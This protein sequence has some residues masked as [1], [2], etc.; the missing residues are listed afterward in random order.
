[1]QDIETMVDKLCGKARNLDGDT[2]AMQVKD[3]RITKDEARERIMR[4]YV[5]FLQDCWRKA[6]FNE[7]MGLNEL[8]VRVP[9]LVLD[10]E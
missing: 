1:M 9:T 4:I 10:M 3:G 7:A 6:P 8:D 2:I 5:A